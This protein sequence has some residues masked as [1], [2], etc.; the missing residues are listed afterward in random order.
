MVVRHSVIQVT[1]G[2][3]AFDL[4]RW[5][6]KILSAGSHS[7]QN[8]RRRRHSTRSWLGTTFSYVAPSLQPPRFRS[9]MD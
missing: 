9:G 3:S 7:A 4:G 5:C 6:S 8:T 1:L 2:K